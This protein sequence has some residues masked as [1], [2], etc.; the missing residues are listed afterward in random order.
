MNTIFKI[1]LPAG[2]K[3]EPNRA[4]TLKEL[5]DM[6]LA[7]KEPR[8]K[9]EYDFDTW[10]AFGMTHEE[11]NAKVREAD[12]AAGYDAPEPEV[13]EK[14][15]NEASIFGSNIFGSTL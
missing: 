11:I 10:R 2:I 12:R 1:N 5:Q 9:S 15:M 7:H 6:G 4:Y 3:L 8:L 13:E 14:E